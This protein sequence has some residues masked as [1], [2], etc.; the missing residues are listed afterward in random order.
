MNKTLKNQVE[1]VIDESSG[2]NV[3]VI[4][5]LAPDQKALGDYVN[6]SSEIINNRSTTVSVRNFLPPSLKEMPQDAT[7]T[8]KFKQLGNSTLSITK[9]LQAAYRYKFMATKTLKAH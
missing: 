9:A 7:D 5:R 4:V 8:K 6:A 3:D 1:K 2:A